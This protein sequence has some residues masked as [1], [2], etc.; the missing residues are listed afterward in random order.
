MD[1]IDIELEHDSPIDALSALKKND[2]PLV[3]AFGNQLL[4]HMVSPAPPY[5]LMIRILCTL[6]EMKAAQSKNLIAILAYIS[7]DLRKMYVTE[8]E[9]EAYNGAHP[10][11][12]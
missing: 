7:D 12:G 5:A 11:A 8:V 4:Q 3:S 1:A 6:V 2:D 10:Q 9:D